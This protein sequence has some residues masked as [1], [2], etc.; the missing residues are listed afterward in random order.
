MKPTFQRVT[1]ARVMGAAPNLKYIAFYH[2][3]EERLNSC[4]N[5]YV[6]RS[7]VYILSADYCGKE[8]FLYAGKSKAQYARMLNHSKKFAYDYIYLFECEPKQLAESERAVISELQPL[9]NKQGNPMWKRYAALLG[10][11]YD[12]VQ[13]KT[14]IHRYL[15]LYEKYNAVELFGFALPP[16]IFALVKQK[17]AA[18]NMTCSEWMQRVLEDVFMD[19]IAA[20]LPQLNEDVPSNLIS[21]ERYGELHKKSREQIKQYLRQRNRIPGVLKVGRDWILPQDAKFPEDQR[22]KQVR[23]GC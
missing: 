13:D 2:G 17:A 10:I 23:K 19:E 5:D 12:V 11:N 15:E 14:A 1:T 6:D 21:T 9:F 20:A 4:M 7:F 16:T 8:Y 18:Q 22:K 3:N